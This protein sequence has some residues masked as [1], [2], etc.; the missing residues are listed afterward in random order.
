[1]RVIRNNAYWIVALIG[2]VCLG[3]AAVG[4]GQQQTATTLPIALDQN[5]LSASFR[6]VAHA[7]LP[8]IVSIET[9]GKAVRTSVTSPFDDDAFRE[10]F[11]GNPRFRDFFKDFNERPNREPHP[12]YRPRGKGS[13]FIIDRSG[14]IMTNS[15]VVRGADE[16]KVRLHDGREFIATDVKT[17]SQSDVA[18]IR[19]KAQNLP[20]ALHLGD[21]D[22]MQIGDWVLAVGSPFGLDLSV[23]A[24]IISAKGRGP[25]IAKRE[26]FL[27][28][29]AAINPGN[30]GGPLLNLNAEVIGIN[31]AI[32]SRS[33]GYDGVGFAIPVNMADWVGRQLIE[34]GKVRRAYLG[35][36]VRPVDNAN[37]ELFNTPIGQGAVVFQVTPDSPAAKIQLEPGDVI[38][39]FNRENVT[40]PRSLQGIV[41]KL[42]IGKAYS[43]LIARNGK[44]LKL[45]VAVGEMPDGLTSVRPV[46]PRSE[47]P[48]SEP[49]FDELGIEIEELT[50]EVAKQLDFRTNGGVLVRSVRPG[51]PAQ[52]AGLASGDVI[53]KVGAKSVKN[54][55]EYRAAMNTVSVNKQILL[56]VRNTNGTRLIV[57]QSNR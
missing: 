53:E 50:S 31:T 15:H 40:G 1:M 16:V 29:D 6:N 35:V 42:Q 32:S 18:I 8:S 19:I 10:F 4:M 20:R 49:R 51:S 36:G 24:G 7:A 55:A 41:E 46:Q 45:K 22:A 52:F 2:G 27:Q 34:L 56:V 14:I 3:A 9:H 54:L 26:N 37:S 28:T 38:L 43:L 21:S 57:I 17:D 39:E 11:R 47:S 30:S 13:G 5:A 33:G 23:T 25:R 12:S 44:K 48:S